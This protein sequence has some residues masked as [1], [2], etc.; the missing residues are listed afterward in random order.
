LSE[1]PI[2]GEG[3]GH[4][5][6]ADYKALYEKERARLAKLWD[7]YVRQEAELEALRTGPSTG[8]GGGGAPQDGLAEPRADSDPREQ[9]IKDLEAELRLEKDRFRNLF[10]LAMDLDAELKQS[11]RPSGAPRGAD[12]RAEDLGRFAQAL[13]AKEEHLLARE[14]DLKA[15]S[16]ALGREREELS[17]LRASL[18]DRVPALEHRLRESEAELARLKARRR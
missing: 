5:D 12:G 4:V 18:L 8:G 3:A 1:R 6:G 11:R 2:D 16:D 14:A 15:E 9:R 10:Q 13:V 17:R 7:A